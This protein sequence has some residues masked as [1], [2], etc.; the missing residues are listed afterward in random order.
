MIQD[1]EGFAEIQSRRTN[2]FALFLERIAFITSYS[3]VFRVLPPVKRKK[4]EIMGS[5]CSLLTL[6][7]AVE[8]FLQFP[9]GDS[10]GYSFPF[11]AGSIR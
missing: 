10:D 1:S 3:R 8:G 2:P 7:I 4:Q 5:G 9:A 11:D 6:K